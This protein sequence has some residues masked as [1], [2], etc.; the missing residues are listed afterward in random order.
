MNIDEYITAH[1]SSEPPELAEIYR[2]THLHLVNPR[3]CSGHLQGRLL[4]ILSSLVRP[5]I[6]VELGTYAAY[7][8]LCIAEGIA[9]G[10]CLHSIEASDELEDFINTSLASSPYGSRV[11]MHYGR[12]LDLIGQIAPGEKFDFAFIDADKREYEA[13]YHALRQRMCSGGLIVAD[14]TLW[15]NHVTD[16]ECHDAQTQGIKAFNNAVSQDNGVENVI[17]PLRDGITLIYV[18]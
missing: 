8:T 12:A 15:D 2:R 4:S 17:L 9:P 10:G 11:K 3:M 18:K 1:I 5:K 14:N 16:P 13:Y 7:S 6:A